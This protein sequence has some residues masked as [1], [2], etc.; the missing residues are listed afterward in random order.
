MFPVYSVQDQNVENSI[1]PSLAQ[2]CWFSV[3]GRILG[4]NWNKSLKSIPPCRSQL[5]LQTDFTPLAQP[6][7][8]K[9]GLKLFCN[10]NIAYGNL[11]SENFQG[12]TQKPQQNCKFKNSAS[13]F[14]PSSRSGFYPYPA[15]EPSLN[16]RQAKRA[17]NFLYCVYDNCSNLI[18]VQKE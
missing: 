9:S 12:Y 5:P 18:S 7:L 16:H 14:Y 17:C 6:P 8:R 13:G 11:R 3:W 2:N 4:R 10:V 1:C 15:M